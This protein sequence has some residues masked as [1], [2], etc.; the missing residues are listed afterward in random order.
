MNGEFAVRILTNDNNLEIVEAIK[1]IEQ[2]AVQFL[3]VPERF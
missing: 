3:I 2:M 1:K